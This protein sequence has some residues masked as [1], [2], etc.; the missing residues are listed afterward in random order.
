M[1]PVLSADQVRMVDARTVQ[2]EPIRSLDL[3]ERAA[4]AFVRAFVVR[5]GDA[6]RPVLV[7]C[8]PGNNGGDGLVM[9]RALTLRGWRV[10]V[11]LAYAPDRATADNRHNLERLRELPVELLEGPAGQ[12]PAL[13]P[14]EWVIDALFGTG[15]DRPLQGSMLQLVKDL[16]ARRAFVVAVD[17]PSGAFADGGPDDPTAV[18]HARATFTFQVPKPFLLLPEH[19]DQVGERHVVD[20]GLDREAIASCAAPHALLEVGDVRPLL[21]VRPRAG[22]KGSFGH[23]LLVA[24]GTGQLGAAVMAVAAALRSGVGLVTAAV[25]RGS[26]PVLH[27]QAPEAM[28]AEVGTGDRPE[29][30]VPAGRWTA[31]GMGP[32]IGTGPAPTGR[33]H[34]VLRSTI[35][36]VLDADALN[37]LARDHALL[38]TLR[39]GTVLTPHPGE[40]DRLFGPSDHTRAR[41]AKA[42]AFARERQVVVVLKGAP[43]AVCLPDGGVRFNGTGNAG[44]AKGG[45][46]DVLTG[47][48][49][50]LLAQG[51]APGDAAMLGTWVHGAAGD[52][53]AATI[54]QDG[55]TAMDLVRALPKGFR[56]LRVEAGR[57]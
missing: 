11:L 49:T 56:R 32:G 50:G 12:L 7:L 2:R 54:G 5:F 53:A 48:L 41:I 24:G 37:I 43:A 26:A 9:A 52:I 13:R 45:S 33:L 15:L 19:A 16:N 55:M 3:M 35:P 25:P 40:A 8:G 31:I 14:G 22:H 21:P 28:V 4:L 57:S 34:D 27:A 38:A 46:G 42:S 51:M 47:L 6:P 17:L 39:P 29:G 10:R 44:M 30:P 20:I 23:A 18:V 1:L 36:L